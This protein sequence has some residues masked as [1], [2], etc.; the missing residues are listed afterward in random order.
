MVRSF[1]VA[2]TGALLADCATTSEPNQFAEARQHANEQFHIEARRIW[3]LYGSAIDAISAAERKSLVS[4]VEPRIANNRLITTGYQLCTSRDSDEERQQCQQR[5]VQVHVQRAAARY[6]LANLQEVAADMK[7]FT[8]AG[9]PADMEGLMQRNH[10]ARVRLLAE[11]Y[12]DQACEVRDHS[13]QLL[14]GE[15]DVQLDRISAA[16]KAHN[17]DQRRQALAFAAALQGFARGFQSGG[18]A[19]PTASAQASGCS[20]DFNCGFGNVCVKPNFSTTGRCARAVNSVGVQTLQAP[21]P[22]SIAPK[23]PRRSECR[24]DTDC[25]ISFSCDVASG[26]CLKR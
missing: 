21:D 22:A 1:L 11:R 8:A 20:S 23:M 7:A 6:F 13:L 2:I 17:D 14:R 3:K 5:V 19:N 4:S 10:N 18:A 9:Q 26:A 12:R 15:R 25:P 16:E 24:F